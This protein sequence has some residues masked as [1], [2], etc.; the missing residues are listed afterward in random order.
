MKRFLSPA[1]ASLT[2]FVTASESIFPI[3]KSMAILAATALLA[4]VSN[5]AT[6]TGQNGYTAPLYG[7]PFTSSTNTSGAISA[8]TAVAQYPLANVVNQ[9]D[10]SSP[11]NS[12]S[13]RLQGTATSGFMQ[14][15]ATSP[16]A[17]GTVISSQIV[18][19]GFDTPMS[20]DV[21]LDGSTVQSGAGANNT[22][23]IVVTTM[24][25]SLTVQTLRLNMLMSTFG[26]NQATHYA[27]MNEVLILPDRLA[28]VPSTATTSSATGT[29]GQLDA[30]KG[31]LKYWFTTTAN[32]SATLT[33]SGTKTISALVLANLE[34]VPGSSAPLTFNILNDANVIVA[35]A[36]MTETSAVGE[37][38]GVKFD[39]PV[40]TSSLKFAFTNTGNDAMIEIIPFETAPV[41][42]PAS[43]GLLA[44]GVVGL[45]GRRSRGN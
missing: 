9:L 39:T 34:T 14:F 24:A 12:T 29:Q 3:G 31:G 30:L 35:S 26:G 40:T 45:L 18:G 22:S 13:E 6:I 1:R 2:S 4:A 37:F 33:F 11:T 10:G 36:S 15:V 27:D 32:S 23:P 5:A 17:A 43:L 7:N 25:P 44:L 8:G 42:E 20:Y 21:L 19:N 16:F 41:P 38:V 28:Y